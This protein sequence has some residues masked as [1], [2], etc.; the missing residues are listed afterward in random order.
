MRYKDLANDSWFGKLAG[1]AL[2]IV[3]LATGF[4]MVRNS[5]V[6]LKAAGVSLLVNNRLKEVSEVAE[7]QEAVLE[8][9]KKT[10]SV[11]LN[12]LKSLETGI[13]E[14]KQK[15]ADT[16]TKLSENMIEQSKEDSILE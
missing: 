11:P 1:I 7:Q 6:E 9:L 13:N 10:R 15:I 2:I 4:S 5:Q 12:T 16:E 14:N 8:N 3:A